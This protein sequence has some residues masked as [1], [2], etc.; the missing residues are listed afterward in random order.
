MAGIFGGLSGD[1]RLQRQMLK[2][3]YN[4]A[5]LNLLAIVIFTLVSIIAR[6]A[7]SNVY[8]V[9]SACI[10]Y[11][12]TYL[13][14]SACGMIPDVEAILPDKSIFYISIAISVL[15]LA[16]YLICWIFSKKNSK[17]LKIAFILFAFDAVAMF[18]CSFNLLADIVSHLLMLWLI[19]SGL[20]ARRQ[21]RQLPKEEEVIEAEFTEI[22]S[23]N[24]GSYTAETSEDTP[25]IEESKTEESNSASSYS[26]N[27]KE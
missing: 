26:E 19:Y 3:K 22:P 11:A 14:M 10:P 27:S 4:A 12:I 1:P 2:N 6:V 7:G 13:G 16:I 18:F 25:L 24:D 8:F 23:D 17:W 21:L 15:I 5:R 20:K 9:F